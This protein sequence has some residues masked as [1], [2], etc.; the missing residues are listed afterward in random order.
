[1]C[2]TEPYP[3]AENGF[4]SSRLRLKGGRLRLKEGT[5]ME[6]LIIIV[7]LILLFGGGFGFYRRR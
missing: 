4:S 3:A 1:V 2:R 6:L 7:V 5:P